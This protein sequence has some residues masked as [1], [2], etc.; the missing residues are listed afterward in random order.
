VHQAGEPMLWRQS[1]RTGRC[2]MRAWSCDGR[3]TCGEV[4]RRKLHIG[5][6][7]GAH[8]SVGVTTTVEQGHSVATV[9]G[10]HDGIVS[11]GDGWWRRWAT[12]SCR[13]LAIKEGATVAGRTSH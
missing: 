6:R 1:A 12:G 3:Q 4:R 13:G 11:T 9:E 2:R 8:R 7:G 5:R 10:L